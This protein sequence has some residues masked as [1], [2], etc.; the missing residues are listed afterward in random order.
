M[1]SPAWLADSPAEL[2]RLLE[3][4][5]GLTGWEIKR[6][7]AGSSRTT[8]IAKSPHKVVFLKLGVGPKYLRRLSELG[9]TPPVLASGRHAGTSFVIQAYAPGHHPAPSWFHK[10]LG[11]VAGLMNKYHRDATLVRWLK[12]NHRVSTW[13]SQLAK[14]HQGLRQLSDSPEKTEA[15]SLWARLGGRSGGPVTHDLAAVHPDP[16]GRFG[17]EHLRR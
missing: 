5:L 10:H 4:Y 1:N 3:R 12:A 9:I 6:P 14:L 8:F 15:L 17:R 13:R 11:Q 7:P 16:D 2:E